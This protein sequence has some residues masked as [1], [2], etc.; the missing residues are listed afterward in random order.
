MQFSRCFRV[1]TLYH[2]FSVFIES[3]NFLSFFLSF[4][5]QFSR[6]APWVLPPWRD[7]NLHGAGRHVIHNLRLHNFYTFRFWRVEVCARSARD[8]PD[9]IRCQAS[10]AEKH[11]IYIFGTGRSG[12]SMQVCFIVSRY[13]ASLFH[14]VVVSDCRQLYRQTCKYAKTNKHYNV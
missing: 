2:A 1:V 5:M 9:H 11:N 7:Y 4:D 14:I 8:T 13:D 10:I 3:A 12:Y 6:C